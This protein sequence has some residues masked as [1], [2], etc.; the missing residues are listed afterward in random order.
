MQNPA[1]WLSLMCDFYNLIY[2][3]RKEWKK[4]EL[5]RPA[6]L[7]LN[8]A[9]CDPAKLLNFSKPWFAHL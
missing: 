6:A 7:V 4:Q 8:F 3:Q 1:W 5:Y 9:W 2:Q